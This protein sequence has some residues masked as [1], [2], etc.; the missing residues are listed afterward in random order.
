MIIQLPC[1]YSGGLLKLRH[2]GKQLGFDMVSWATHFSP[3]TLSHGT[4]HPFLLY[5]QQMQ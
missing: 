5:S 1:S 2:H 4:L 3:P